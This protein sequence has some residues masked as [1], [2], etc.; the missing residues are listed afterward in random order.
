MSSRSA[1]ARRRPPRKKEPLPPP[2]PPAERTVGQLVAEALR[3]YGA[4]FWRA[5]ALGVPPALAGVALTVIPGYWNLA[6]ALTIGAGVL[7]A[8]YIAAT[9]LASGS[10]P[11][12]R[13]LLTAFVVGVLVFLPVPFLSRFFILPAVAW[14]ALVGLSVP[15]AVVEGLRP[16][17]AVERAIR[18]AS[19]DYVHAMGGLATLVL[20][21]L[22]SSLVLFF[23]LRGQGEATLA[24]AA[25]LAVVVVSPVVFLGGALLY[26]DQAARLARADEAARKL[27]LSRG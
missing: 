26:F 2:L 22:L 13:A 25:F 17:A 23:L 19:V 16:R 11:P 12:R 6:F 4:N 8:S 7:T 18:L 3:L 27:P 14:L 20:L 24:A 9:V 21:G 10:R 15:A 1:K 5:I